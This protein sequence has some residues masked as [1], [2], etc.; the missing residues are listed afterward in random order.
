MLINSYHIILFYF[1][2]SIFHYMICI[3]SLF[4]YTFWKFYEGGDV[5]SPGHCFIPDV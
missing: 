2:Q 1:L 5:V 4:I 3:Y